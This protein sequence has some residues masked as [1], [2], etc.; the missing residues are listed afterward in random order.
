MRTFMILTN[1][2]EEIQFKALTS[3]CEKELNTRI[4]MEISMGKDIS[5]KSIRK[6]MLK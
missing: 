1:H 5:L 6:Q 3:Y 4:H 2:L